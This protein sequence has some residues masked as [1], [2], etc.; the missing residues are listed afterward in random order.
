MCNL[1]PLPPPLL[2]SLSAVLKTCWDTGQKLLPFFF[3]FSNHIAF[4]EQPQRVLQVQD[5]V[6]GLHSI[7][8]LPIH[9]IPVSRPPAHLAKQTADNV[10]KHAADGTKTGDS[11]KRHLQRQIPVGVC[12][13][14]G[15]V[16]VDWVDRWFSLKKTKKKN[17]RS[18]RRTRSVGG[19]SDASALS[20][21]KRR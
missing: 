16:A 2:H 4:S 5:P 12:H 11:R 17:P 7:I 8:R 19:I 1:A 9:S 13:K 3:F 20:S 21:E 18:A 14:A 6:T 15:W 10:H